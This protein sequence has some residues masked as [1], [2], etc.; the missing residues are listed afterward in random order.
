MRIYNLNTHNENKR[1]L[2]SILIGL[3]ASILMGYLFYLVSRWFTFRLDI[4][5]IVIAYTISLLLKKVGRDV[6]KKFSIL[7]ACLAFV[8]II[9]GDALILFGKNAINLL[10][11]AIFF[12]Q[13]IRI[14]VYSLTANLNAL[15]GLLIR[16]SAIYEAYYYSVLF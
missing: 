13:F 14:E 8:A 7:G 11:N 10:T 15:I 12:S 6:T 2:L 16:V 4:F 5:Y 9:V 3:P 1:F